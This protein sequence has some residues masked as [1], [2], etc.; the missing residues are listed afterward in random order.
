VSSAEQVGFVSPTH[1]TPRNRRY[2]RSCR[3]R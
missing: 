1:G 3:T 2:A